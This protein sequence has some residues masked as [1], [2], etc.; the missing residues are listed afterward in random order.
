MLPAPVSAGGSATELPVSGAAEILAT[1]ASGVGSWA[2]SADATLRPFLFLGLGGVLKVPC[3]RLPLV[4]LVFFRGFP[5]YSLTYWGGVFFPPPPPPGGV[6][7]GAPPPDGPPDDPPGDDEESPGE[8]PPL[9]CPPEDLL[10]LVGVLFP[11]GAFLLGR[12]LAYLSAC[13]ETLVF[14]S[15]STFHEQVG[16]PWRGFI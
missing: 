5:R 2:S 14:L 1:D 9:P 13:G 16:K 12:P 4:M 7:P 10:V 11:L 15:I 6:P 8:P 3:K